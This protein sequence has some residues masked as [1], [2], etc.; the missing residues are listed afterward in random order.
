MSLQL[1]KHL[2][3]LLF[4]ERCVFCGKVTPQNARCCPTCD[5]RLRRAGEEAVYAL[6]GVTVYSCFY[7]KERCRSALDRFKF[8]GERQLA[9]YFAAEMSKLA[10]EQFDGFPFDCVAY[11]P[12]PELRKQGRGYNQGQLLA[13][14]VAHMQ[15]VPCGSCGLVR[16]E[17]FAQHDLNGSMRRKQAYSGFAMEEGTV[18]SG[19]IL[20]VDDVTTT[21][22][23]LAGC[24]K[25]L[26]QAGAEKITAIT[27]AR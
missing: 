10:E 4:P 8:R 3:A 27:A 14:A 13:E 21:G 1:F 11:L 20:L 18:L 12:M 5:S 6:P 19:R 17:I 22:S 15:G 26:R 2:A 24:A 25:L 16:P 7:Y 23:S 9:D